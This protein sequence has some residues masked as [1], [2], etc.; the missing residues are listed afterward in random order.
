VSAPANQPSPRRRRPRAP[1]PAFT[2]IE[3]LVVVAIL[4]VVLGVVS[5]SLSAGIRAWEAVRTFNA[6][7]ADALLALQ[8]VSRDV[9]GAPAFRPIP[10]TGE[11]EELRCPVRLR[12]AATG[13]ARLAT[14]R[15]R[16]DRAAGTL[17]RSRWPYPD[18]EP[19]RSAEET[20]AR[21]LDG[22]RVSYLPAADGEWTGEWTGR[23]NAPVAIRL[24][25][26]TGVRRTHLTETIALRNRGGPPQ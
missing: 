16:Y 10:I 12:D 5:A 15:F 6:D 8:L 13:L 21:R 3:L 26:W 23:T 11:A 14:A 18:E 9:A 24:E 7:E 2:L 25:T 1:S 19:G 4:G 17:T 22:F 20:L